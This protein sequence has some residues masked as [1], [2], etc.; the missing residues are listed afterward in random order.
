MNKNIV[1]E[2]NVNSLDE[3]LRLIEDFKHFRNKNAK[4]EKRFAIYKKAER[5]SYARMVTFF[6]LI[7]RS[8]IDLNEKDTIKI[9][10]IRRKI[11]DAFVKINKLSKKFVTLLDD[12]AKLATNNAEEFMKQNKF[13]SRI[14]LEKMFL[15]NDIKMLCLLKLKEIN[16]VLVEVMNFYKYK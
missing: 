7:R 6:K 5:I 1:S 16:E 2:G 14:L 12:D 15:M 9:N 3:K 13:N 8:G 4:S 10:E 11:D